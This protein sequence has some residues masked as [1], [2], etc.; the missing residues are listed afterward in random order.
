MKIRKD[1]LQIIILSDNLI[2]KH[3][4]Y[5]KT[6]IQTVATSLTL[7]YKNLSIQ[8]IETD[9]KSQVNAAIGVKFIGR[10]LS[11]RNNSKGD[12]IRD[13]CKL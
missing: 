7:P 13:T 1:T 12:Q 10:N 4:K 8:F 3:K 5:I 2:N 11:K 6:A 9:N